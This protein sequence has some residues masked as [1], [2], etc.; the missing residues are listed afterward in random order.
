MKF[1]KP[2]TL[3]MGMGNDTDTVK[4]IWPFFKKI[5]IRTT[6][7][8]LEIPLLSIYQKKLKSAS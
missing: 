8:E 4:T 1:W 2:C 5:K 7:Y 6:I 3:L